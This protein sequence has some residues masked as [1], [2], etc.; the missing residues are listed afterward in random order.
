[1]RTKKEIMGQ[2]IGKE[3]KEIA[4]YTGFD[5]YEIKVRAGILE[6]LLDIRDILDESRNEH[7]GYTFPEKKTERQ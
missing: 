3:L 2:F 7:F 6:A 4:E 1:M 5:K